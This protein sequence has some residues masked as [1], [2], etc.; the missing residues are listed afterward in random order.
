[1]GK[2]SGKTAALQRWGGWI[3]LLYSNPFVGM[4]DFPEIQKTRR[5]FSDSG[6]LRVI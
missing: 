1:M 3:G 2:A 6:N 4:G 5:F